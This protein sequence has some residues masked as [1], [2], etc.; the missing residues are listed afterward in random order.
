MSLGAIL[1]ISVFKIFV[2]IVGVFTSVAIGIWL[3]FRL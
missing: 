3:S 1:I 2:Y